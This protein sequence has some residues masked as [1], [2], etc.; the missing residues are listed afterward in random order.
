MNVRLKNFLK[1]L[2][3]TLLTLGFLYLAFRGI[4]FT[5][6]YEILLNTNYWWILSMFPVLLL[7][8]TIRAY[9]WKFLLNPVKKDLKFRNLFSALVI[10]YMM[11]NVLPRVGEIVRPYA[12]GKLEN[13]SRSAAFATVLVERIFDILSFLIL[14]ALIP[15][16]YNGPLTETFPW[17]ESTGIW[18]TIATFIFLGF[19]IFFMLRRDLVEK[20]LGYLKPHLSEKHS[21]LINHIVLSFL[22][23]FLFFKNRQ[24]YF[25]IFVTNALIWGLYIIMMYIPFYAF[26][27][28]EKYNLD[29]ASALVVQAISSI[30]ILIP[31]PGATGPYHYFT[32]QTL[33]KLYN[34]D[35]ELAVSYATLTHAV[36]FIGITLVGVFYFLKDKMSMSEIM[37]QN[38]R[39]ENKVP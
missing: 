12:I 11:N 9:R 15:L 7:S 26:G 28:V 38:G 29:L 35:T 8:H 4:D 18:V 39:N 25:V 31:T 32:I 27:L 17:L 33:T 24:N 23:G 16:V 37:K 30:G 34:V 10:G 20:F 1:Y 6:L 3:S 13:V 5:K 14:I 2:T 36:G 19:F 21:N 22:D